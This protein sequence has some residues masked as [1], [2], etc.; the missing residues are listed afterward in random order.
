MKPF[1]VIFGGACLA[2]IIGFPSMLRAE[3]VQYTHIY[4]SMVIPV[5]TCKSRVLEKCATAHASCAYYCTKSTRN[6]ADANA[7]MACISN[8]DA[9]HAA[10]ETMAC[11]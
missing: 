3:D 5:G 1:S 11:Q 4:R 8:C 2:L 9:S 6:G 7:F 10:C